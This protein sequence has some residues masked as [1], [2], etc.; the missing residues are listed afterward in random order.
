MIDL[1]DPNES[2]LALRREFTERLPAQRKQIE[3]LWTVL[4]ERHWQETSLQA[5]LHIV[6]KMA[7]SAFSLG[8]ETLGK[9]ARELEIALK[10][11]QTV[12][13]V[14]L[15][16]QDDARLQQLLHNLLK[17]INA[18][19]LDGVRGETELENSL[20]NSE[21][22]HATRAEML[23]YLVEDDAT[24]ADELSAQIRYF[25][26]QVHTFN[27][28]SAARAALQHTIP[29]AILM[30]MIFPEGDAAGAEALVNFDADLSEKTAIV[31]ISVRD[32]L[33]A[34]LYAVRAGGKAYFTKPIN[35]GALID[36]LDRL[37]VVEIQPP[38]RV[39]I[40]DDSAVQANINAMHLKKAGIQT[41]IVTEPLQALA[42]LNDFNPDLIL[43]DLYMPECSG[44]ELARAIRQIESFISVPIVYLSA[45]T[46]RD[47][48]LAAVGLGGDDFLTKPIKPAHLVS[49]VSSRVERYRQM[50]NLIVR[51]SLTG[52]FNHT[53]IKERLSQ[54]LARAMRLNIPLAFAMLDI[55]HFKRVNDTYGH[56]A[57]DRVLKNLANLLENRLRSSDIVGRYGGEEFAI[58]FTNTTGSTAAAVLNKA[59]ENFAEVLHQVGGGDSISVT[60]S[61]GVAEFPGCITPATLSESADKALYQAKNS[62]RNRVVLVGC[63]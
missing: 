24:Q 23:V 48:Q 53:T 15:T 52:L 3:T 9:A 28:L 16:P 61:G 4:M 42:P 45:E 60:F 22:L 46:D 54:E 56:N 40:I 26:Y 57:G 63:S 8:Y 51:D 21:T 1:V 5:L 14:E 59:R 36:T 20:K 34:R 12:P 49:A 43:L 18:P 44:L 32:D 11:L 37:T 58:I 13:S 25:G 38:F 19:R 27:D 2:M 39:L 29:A 41:H 55:D 10:Q 31:F 35:V 30:D 50:R 7:G 6:H 47:K 62:G 33:Q 17:H